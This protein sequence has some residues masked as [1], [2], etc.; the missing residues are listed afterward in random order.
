M[1]KKSVAAFIADLA[2]DPNLQQELAELAAKHG[3]DFTSD[4]LN[5]SDM[6][7]ISGG[8]LNIPTDIMVA[9]KKPAKK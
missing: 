6:A 1:S 3:Y 5:D 4:E 7:G 9:K 2:K 8:V